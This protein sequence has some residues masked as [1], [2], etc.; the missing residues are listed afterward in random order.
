VRQDT[1]PRG[2]TIPMGA[3]P[4][5]ARGLGHMA[6]TYLRRR[7]G[8]PSNGLLGPALVFGLGSAHAI[9]TMSLA[10][11][12]PKSTLRRQ[13]LERR[14]AVEPATRAALSA[15]LAAVGLA[16]AER[17]RPRVVAAFSP[18]RDEPD[19][20][21]LIA[22]LQAH[23]LTTAL[24][25]VDGRAAPLV[26]RLW[27]AGD[28]LVRGAWG[29]LEP[30]AG[31]PAVSPDLVFV[32]LA[33]FDRRGHRL[34]YGAGHYDR[35]LKLLRAGGPIRAVGVAYAAAEV[36]RVPDEPHDER[37]DFVLTEREWIDARGRG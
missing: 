10:A 16:W 11:A 2:R 18:L 12:D 24:P 27:R 33:A 35:A 8:S 15:R 31:A 5:L 32:P 30:G 34:G 22:A 17:W 20:G 26:F 7:P 29:P 3:V 28:P 6:P 37:L 9:A 25:A 23:G 14:R 1:Y 4:V 19:T 21:P 13:A 36:D